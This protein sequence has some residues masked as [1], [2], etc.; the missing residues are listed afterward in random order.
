MSPIQT[1][2]EE[3]QEGHSSLKGNQYQENWKS[4]NISLQVGVSKTWL[5][6]VLLHSHQIFTVQKIQEMQNNFHKNA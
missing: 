3:V 5:Y 4:I 2:T 1:H 6:H